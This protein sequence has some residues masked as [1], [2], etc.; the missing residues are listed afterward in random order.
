MQL[1][2]ALKLKTLG[3]TFSFV[4]L[5]RLNCAKLNRKMVSPWLVPK[6]IHVWLFWCGSLKFQP[7][8]THQVKHTKIQGKNEHFYSDNSCTGFV[9]PSEAQTEGTIL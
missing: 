4:N 5:N 7:I 3:L 8:N 1:D 6:K 2:K 9:P